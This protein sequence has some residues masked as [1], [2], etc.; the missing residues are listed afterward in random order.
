M[1]QLFIVKEATSRMATLAAETYAGAFAATAAIPFIGPAM[2]PGVAA[3]S[4]AAMLSGATAAGTAGGALGSGL[5]GVAHGGLDYVPRTGT[6]LLEKGEKVTP[7]AENISDDDIPI[8]ELH[9]NLDSRVLAK[10]FVHRTEIDSMI[11]N[12]L[13]KALS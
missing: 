8:L 3:A 2:A 11:L 1:A 13:R 5:A 9:V 7:A 4:T 10:S 6:Y 12:R